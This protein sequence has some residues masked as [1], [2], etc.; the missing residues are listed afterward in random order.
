MDYLDGCEQAQE[1]AIQTLGHMQRHGIPAT[2]P[3]FRVWYDYAAGRNPTLRAALDVMI[4]NRREFSAKVCDEIYEQFYSGHHESDKVRQISARVEEAITKALHSIDVAGSGTAQF[5][6]ALSGFSGQVTAAGRDGQFQSIIAGIVAET[7]AMELRN[8]ELE[9]QL[10]STSSEMGQLRT[11]LD[12]IRREASLDPLTGIANRKV[13]DNSLTACAAEAMESGSELCLLMVDIDHFKKFNDSWGHQVGDQV[14]KLVARTLK[15]QARETDVS[16]RYG[17]E[18]FA[19]ILP[20]TT[21]KQAVALAN[22]IRYALTDK[23]LVKK[24]TGQDMGRITASIGVAR[25]D[26]G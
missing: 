25:F 8:A 24:S 19:V 11:H 16:A 13:F 18:E 23:Q 3:N 9:R 14:L 2:P 22:Q 7:K 20:N 12:E 15:D 26:Y 5:G 21:L 6:E 1:Y 17:G 10:T 4:S